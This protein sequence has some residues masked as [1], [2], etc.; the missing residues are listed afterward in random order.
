MAFSI[1][2]SGDQ[3][4]SLPLLLAP[5]YVVP[6]DIT[7]KAD[8]YGMA[9]LSAKFERIE[10]DRSVDLVLLKPEPGTITLSQAFE[11]REHMEALRRKKIG[12]ACYLTEATTS[13]YM[14]C[15]G[16]DRIWINPAGGI[17]LAGLSTQAVF[18]KNLLEAFIQLSQKF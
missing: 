17:R 4:P 6:I 10:N 16:A 1:R 11:I 5:A 18:F 13:V 3:A 15:A 8:T 9:A 12:T 7:E 14:A 2:L